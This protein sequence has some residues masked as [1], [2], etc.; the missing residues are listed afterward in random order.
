MRVNECK[1]CGFSMQMR[2][3]FTGVAVVDIRPQSVIRLDHLKM[4]VCRTGL[5]ALLVFYCCLASAEQ[6]T[7]QHLS[8][9]F[10]IT[11]DDQLMMKR[12]K[13]GSIQR[14]R[15][16]GRS[17]APIR[18]GHPDEVKMTGKRAFRVKMTPSCR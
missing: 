15:L 1:L 3:T 8:R 7:Q 4:S 5:A 18:F 12:L 10:E 16:A 11:D 9:T 14:L 13:P 2:L 17:A 6:Q